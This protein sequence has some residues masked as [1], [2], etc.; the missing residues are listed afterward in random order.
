MGEEGVE[1]PRLSSQGQGQ[2]A[3]VGGTRPAGGRRGAQCIEW[4][5]CLRTPPRFPEKIRHSY[6][7]LL[8]VRVW[9]PREHRRARE[10]CGYRYGIRGDIRVSRV[11]F[12][13][14]VEKRAGRPRTE[15]GR[16][17]EAFR[18]EERADGS[19]VSAPV[20]HARSFS[21]TVLAAG[22]IPRPL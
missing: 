14:Q 17:L 13:L 15:R 16:C 7:R 8:P 12:D 4:R 6:A 1:D 21:P 9:E 19:E 11:R 5:V 18:C 10:S 20:L 2:V 3:G 22:P